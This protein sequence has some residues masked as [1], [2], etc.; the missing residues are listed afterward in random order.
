MRTTLKNFVWCTWKGG[1]KCI[2]NV[3]SFIFLIH[4]YLTYLKARNLKASLIHDFYPIS[5]YFYMLV[6]HPHVPSIKILPETCFSAILLGNEMSDSCNTWNK[7]DHAIT[8]CYWSEIVY[9]VGIGFHWSH[10]FAIFGT[11][12]IHLDCYTLLH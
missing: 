5:I 4:F 7:S 2:I 11:P 1:R 3:C 10:Q 8:T 9:K 12:Q 6:C